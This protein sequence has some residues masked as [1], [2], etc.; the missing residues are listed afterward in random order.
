MATFAFAV[1]A[2]VLWMRAQFTPQT[3]FFHILVPTVIQGGAVA[4]FF[5][6]LTGLALSS[7]KPEEMAG[8]AG[9]MNFTRTLS[10]A[11]SCARLCMKSLTP[12]LEAA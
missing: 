3:D 6:P 2:L 4:F 1:F 10:G 12:P 11:T 5:I 8:A 7:V 9:L